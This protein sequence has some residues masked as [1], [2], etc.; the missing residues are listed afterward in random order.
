MQ[1]H[2]KQAQEAAD[3]AAAI[4]AKQPKALVATPGDVAKGKAMVA[5]RC[6]V[7]H[8]PGKGVKYEFPAKKVKAMFDSEWLV[9]GCL[10]EEEGNAPELGLSL[11][12]K[13]ALLAF[14][15][16]DGNIVVEN[17]HIT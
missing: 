4:E 14:K 10:S 1:V 9:H 15:N 17:V 13:Q 2:V 6:D 12:Q 3:I 11:D 5:Q 7:C 8:Q 16:I